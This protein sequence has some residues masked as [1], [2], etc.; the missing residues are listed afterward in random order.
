MSIM[1][2]S[3]LISMAD[4]TQSNL[5]IASHNVQGLNSPTKRRNI[6]DYYKSLGIDILLLQETHFPIRYSPKYIHPHFPQFHLASAKNKTKGVAIIFS[7]YYKFE[8]TFEY[9]D[10]EGRILLIKGTIEGHLY[11]LVSCYVPNKGRAAFFKTVM[12]TLN[13]M[14]EGMIIFGGHSNTAFD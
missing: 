9:I 11:S 10:P 2:A 1:S 5:K 4:T 14:L 3:L 8:K 6:L 12:D 7:K 13:P